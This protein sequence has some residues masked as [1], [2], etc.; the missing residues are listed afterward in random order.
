MNHPENL[1]GLQLSLI[2]DIAANGLDQGWGTKDK[3]SS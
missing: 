3:E 1:S 2:N